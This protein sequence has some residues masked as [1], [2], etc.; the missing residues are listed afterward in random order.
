M[1]RLRQM[2]DNLVGIVNIPAD[3]I[4]VQE[5]QDGIRNLLH[6]VQPDLSCGLPIRQKN[7]IEAKPVA[8]VPVPVNNNPFKHVTQRGPGNR[9][10]Q[11]PPDSPAATSTKISSS[12][13]TITTSPASPMTQDNPQERLSERWYRDELARRAAASSAATSQLPTPKDRPGFDS[14][15]IPS[16][17]KFPE[18]QRKL[19]APVSWIQQFDE[20][21]P[22]LMD[23][24]STLH[25]AFDSEYN[26]V[27]PSTPIS[28]PT[29]QSVHYQYPH[30]SSPNLSAFLSYG[31]HP[32]SNNPFGT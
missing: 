24:T 27:T 3:S 31:W 11:C 16:S 29:S 6:E 25:T 17:S 14:S 22:L 4:T 12:H 15:S 32:S 26:Q 28:F 20:R 5:I 8:A 1:E 18:S 7:P 30:L 21:A 10:L 9:S 19:E 13:Y 2:A 23:P